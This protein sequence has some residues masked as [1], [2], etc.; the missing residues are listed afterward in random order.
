MEA[1]V[2]GLIAE[3]Y[4]ADSVV[5][6]VFELLMERTEVSD[7]QKARAAEILA[8]C[9]SGLIGGGDEA[10]MLTRSLTQLQLVLRS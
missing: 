8:E 2:K 5:L 10:L 3:A 7:L 4:Q 1:C 6:Q 9:D